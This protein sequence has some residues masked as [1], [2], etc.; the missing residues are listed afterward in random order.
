MPKPLS[1][2]E[3]RKLHIENYLR[4]VCKD[5]LPEQP[6]MHELISEAF[7]Q[8]ERLK[9][10]FPKSNDTFRD[11]LTKMGLDAFPQLLI[12]KKLS[13]FD[14]RRLVKSYTPY[15]VLD[16]K[17]CRAYIETQRGDGSA[18][19]IGAKNILAGLSACWFEHY[20]EQ[21]IEPLLKP[22]TAYVLYH[23]GKHDCPPKDTLSCFSPHLQR[24]V[25][26]TLMSLIRRESNVLKEEIKH[27]NQLD[28]P[29][30]YAGIGIQFEPTLGQGL[31]IKKI[32]KN[33]PAEKAGLSPNTFITAVKDDT[34]KWVDLTTHDAAANTKQ[35]IRGLP[36]TR[37][38]IKTDTGSEITLRRD[39]IDTIKEQRLAYT[40]DNSPSHPKK[41]Q[42][43]IA[44]EDSAPIASPAR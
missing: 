29:P 28:K 10:I 9:N 36:G 7:H 15:Y 41:W 24:H 14:P 26:N 4:D 20:I 2:V 32:F 13:R 17:Q 16:I 30:H 6:L 25:S 1:P 12:P 34:G 33:S 23:E 35:F 3:I 8:I 11:A 21:A 19:K 38:T 27:N 42:K 43:Y 5:A 18:A 22:Q 44:R 31:L 37:L 40:L 39:Y